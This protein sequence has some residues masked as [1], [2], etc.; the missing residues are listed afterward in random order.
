MIKKNYGL[1][2]YPVKHSLSAA[3]HNAAFNYLKIN[4]EYKLFE[5]KP[6]DLESF[7]LKA[8]DEKSVCG[9]NVTIPHKIKAKEI[10]DG[11]FKVLSDYDAVVAGAINTINIEGGIKY[12]NT[13]VS[14]FRDLLVKDLRFIH[15]D[16]IVFIFGCGG[17]GRAVVAALLGQDRVSNAEKIFIFDA[18]P[19]ALEAAKNHFYGL[20]ACPQRFFCK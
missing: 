18:N 2:G 1:I 10:I 5:V 7:L 8:I 11:R 4:A 13:D 3:M 12:K 19:T 6:E 16:K 17:A 15:K 9:F 20:G 14:G